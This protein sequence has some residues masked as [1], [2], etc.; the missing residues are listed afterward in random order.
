MLCYLLS[1]KKEVFTKAIVNFVNNCFYYI[2]RRERKYE[3]KEAC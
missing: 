3:K 2:K 1:V